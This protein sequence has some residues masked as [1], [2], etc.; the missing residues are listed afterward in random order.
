M[1]GDATYGK[2]GGNVGGGS[3]VGGGG[4]VVGGGGSVVVVGGIV[5]VVLGGSVV[6]VVVGL[7][8]VVVGLSVVVVVLGFVV[9]VVPF[10]AVVSGLRPVPAVVEGAS[11]SP[12]E[13][14]M[15][16][17]L[18]SPFFEAF[19]LTVPATVVGVVS[20][21]G[22]DAVVSTTTVAAVDVEVEV[23]V[24]D[25]AAPFSTMALSVTGSSSLEESRLKLTTITPAATRTIIAINP[26][27][28]GLRSRSFPNRNA[29]LHL[30]R[31]LGSNTPRERSGAKPHTTGRSVVSFRPPSTRGWCP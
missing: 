4:S 28:P 22:I 14:L 1:D 19:F 12:D 15:P 20:G 5:V 2:N 30:V 3:V 7:T 24:D 17:T 16:P 9:A 21:G 11:G 23:E 18:V 25:C 6:V 13:V 31:E 26:D 8:V 29:A 27:L 10:G